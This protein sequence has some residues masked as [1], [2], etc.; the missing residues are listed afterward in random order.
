MN[1]LNGLSSL[2]KK[3]R[4]RRRKYA[5]WKSVMYQA[6]GLMVSISYALL[7]MT[8]TVAKTTCVHKS[9]LL[10]LFRWIM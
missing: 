6:T 4:R 3:K 10:I 8:I 1:L 2:K 9:A 5:V 7:L